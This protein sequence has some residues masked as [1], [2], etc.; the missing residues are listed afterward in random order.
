MFESNSISSGNGQRL[1]SEKVRK[2]PFC[3][4]LH[5]GLDEKCQGWYDDI[6]VRHFLGW[7]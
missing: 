2:G 5:E 7:S 6:V 1:G 4:A 3:T